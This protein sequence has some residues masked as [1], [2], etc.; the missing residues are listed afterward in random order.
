M[1]IC[2]RSP[3]ENNVTTYTWDANHRLATI[4]DG[5]NIVYLTN[6]Y[7]GKGRVDH[8]TLA[9]PNASYSLAY[10]TDGS[11]NVMQTDVTNPRGFTKRLVFN[12]SHYVT[13][14]IEALNQ[15]EQRTTTT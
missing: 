13:S 14:A 8:Q 2:Q 4:K 9:D 5:R 10:T 7:D 12:A 3:P 15:P 6:H 1:A 11:G